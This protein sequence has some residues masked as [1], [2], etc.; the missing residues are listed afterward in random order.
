MALG[1]AFADISSLLTEK[2]SAR[3]LRPPIKAESPFFPNPKTENAIAL[4][5]LTAMSDRS[6]NYLLCPL[7]NAIDNSIISNAIAIVSG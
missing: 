7:V 5:Y 3:M 2:L 4:I 1:E 6:N